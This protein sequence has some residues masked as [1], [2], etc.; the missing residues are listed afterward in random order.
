[1]IHILLHLALSFYSSSK[2]NLL[3]CYL[4]AH[5]DLLVLDLD[6]GIAASSESLDGLR[7]LDLDLLLLSIEL[8]G[9]HAWGA[10]TSFSHN[11][12]CVRVSE[13]KN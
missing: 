10:T 1:M 2:Q 11:K 3:T 13:S 6:P 7:V 5:F 9:L 8:V 4:L 12:L